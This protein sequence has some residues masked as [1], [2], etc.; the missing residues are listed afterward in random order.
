MSV[1]LYEFLLN[2]I[3]LFQSLWLVYIAWTYT[4]LL[5]LDLV[6][7]A[8]LSPGWFAS[9]FAV[10]MLGLLMPILWKFLPNKKEYQQVRPI[11][12]LSTVWVILFLL[13]RV[14]FQEALTNYNYSQRPPI[15]LNLPE[16]AATNFYVL[17]WVFILKDTRLSRVALRRF[18]LKRPSFSW[19]KLLLAISG[20]VYLLTTGY[21][22]FVLGSARLLFVSKQFLQSP[23]VVT[24][25]L[26][27]F[28]GIFYHYPFAENKGV[29]RRDDLYLYV[30]YLGMLVQ[31]FFFEAWRDYRLAL[32]IWDLPLDIFLTQIVNT[33]CI[34]GIIITA[35]WLRGPL[36]QRN[37]ISKE[38]EALA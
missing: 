26:V 27:S 29:R 37:E 6:R 5:G 9:I 38:G 30:L 16:L 24:V 10:L 35:C 14:L 1:R 12:L 15:D 36:L 17:S 22:A 18:L 11:V 32:R 19:P 21:Q 31:S 23:L 20:T 3:F 13:L 7:Q 25:L 34:G 33:V 8:F 28:L 4:Q 2:S